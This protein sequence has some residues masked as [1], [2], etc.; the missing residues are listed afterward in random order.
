MWSASRSERRRISEGKMRIASTGLKR[1]EFERWMEKWRGRGAEGV[2][3]R[4]RRVV[5]KKGRAVGRGR[6]KPQVELQAIISTEQG[7]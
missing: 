3:G 7:V 6:N 2:E 1:G 4:W 5:G